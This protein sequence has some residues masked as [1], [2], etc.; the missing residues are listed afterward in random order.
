M[1]TGWY[2]NPKIFQNK[3][4]SLRAG[5]GPCPLNPGPVF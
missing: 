1:L 3:F 5:T 2:L 4:I